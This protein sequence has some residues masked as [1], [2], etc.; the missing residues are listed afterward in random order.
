MLKL[1]S[2]I[3]PRF[4]FLFSILLLQGCKTVSTRNEDRSVQ[5]GYDVVCEDKEDDSVVMY[6]ELHDKKITKGNKGA[7]MRGTRIKYIG[8][9]VPVTGK[10]AEIGKQIIDI[11]ALSIKDSRSKNV[12]IIVFN[13]GGD[14]ALDSAKKAAAMGVDVVIGPVLS[15][16]T[17]AIAHIFNEAKIEVISLSNDPEVAKK[18][19]NVFGIAQDSLMSTI[20][21]YA[22]NAGYSNFAWI[23]PSTKYG[24]K[25]GKRITYL[26]NGMHMMSI[27]GEYYPTQRRMFSTVINRVVFGRKKYFHVNSEGELYTINHRDKE[28]NGSK[29]VTDPL[30]EKVVDAIYVDA[31][32]SDLGELVK[33]LR[34]R[35][36]KWNKIGLFS[37][38]P[39][40]SFDIEYARYEEGMM[41]AGVADNDIK[42]LQVKIKRTFGYKPSRVGI[43]AYDAIA[44]VIYMIE[45]GNLGKKLYY[46]NGYSGYSGDFRFT[47]SGIVQRRYGIYRVNNNNVEK[48]Y[49]MPMFV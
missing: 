25:A 7:L 31:R 28:K 11:A 26:L 23:L 41:I 35:D 3:L 19:V 13:T 22:K 43:L 40:P 48:V 33:E 24:Y 6:K 9:L 36:L 30:V 16:N 42:Q 47:N 49:K 45:K 1:L 38:N 44:T 37:I 39:F 34:S 12:K 2:K 17:K 4:I 46:N 18:G 27:V 15:E 14:L 32:G 29:V 10:Y 8:L 20:L 5:K 21:S